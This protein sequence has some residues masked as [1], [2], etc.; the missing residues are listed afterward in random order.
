MRK[1]VFG[2][3]AEG[4]RK[5]FGFALLLR[6]NEPRGDDE[7]VFNQMLFLQIDIW[8]FFKLQNLLVPIDKYIYYVPKLTIVFD[9]IDKCISSNCSTDDDDAGKDHDDRED[10]DN[11]FD[12]FNQPSVMQ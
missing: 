11:S 8:I 7:Y 1:L 5:L 4:V 2:E 10:D 9:S 3:V 6:G 12:A